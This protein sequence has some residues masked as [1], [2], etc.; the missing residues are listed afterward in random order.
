MA[1]SKKTVNEV[2]SAFVASGLNTKQLVCVPVG[3]S[4]AP[5]S[6]IMMDQKACSIVFQGP[7]SRLLDVLRGIT[8]VTS[9]SVPLAEEEG[10]L[11]KV[12]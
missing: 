3:S 6:W 9:G 10:H 4:D 2:M 12:G 8:L 7:G 1:K 11:S 5:E